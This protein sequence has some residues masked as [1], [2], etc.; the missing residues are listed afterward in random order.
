[1]YK[2]NT[3]DA[4]VHYLLRSLL[5]TRNVLDVSINK[6]VMFLLHVVLPT[7]RQLML[8]WQT[9]MSIIIYIY[10]IKTE[11]LDQWIQLTQIF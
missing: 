4:S 3:H 5:I 6:L 8:R 7:E 9:K 10:N 1:M 2:H 11:N